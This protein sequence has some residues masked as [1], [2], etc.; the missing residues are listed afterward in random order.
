MEAFRKQLKTLMFEQAAAISCNT[1]VI[2]NLEERL[3]LMRENNPSV[4]LK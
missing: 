3:P 1:S 4:K 2:P